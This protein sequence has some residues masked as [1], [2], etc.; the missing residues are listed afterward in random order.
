MPVPTETFRSIRTLNI[1]FAASAAF[2]L[3]ITGWLIVDDWTRAWRG[4]QQDARAWQ[5]VLTADTLAQTDSAQLRMDL[6]Q[7]EEEIR[8]MRAALP[9]QQLAD[10]ERD[11]A[12]MDK[13]RI[14]LELPLARTKSEIVPTEQQIE[15]ARLQY[16]EDA[17]ETKALRERLRSIII[18]YNEKS[19][20]LEKHMA[21]MTALTEKVTAFRKAEEDQKKD[22]ENLDR[23]RRALADK[24]SK[25]APDN[26]AS[27]FGE[28]LR[29]APLLDWFNPSEKIEQVIVPGVRTDLNFLTVETA[30]ACQTCHIN[31]DRPEFVQADLVKFLQR[32]V[33]RTQYQDVETIDDAVVSVEFWER[34]VDKLAAAGNA[35]VRLD[36]LRAQQQTL[37]RINTLRSEAADA[38]LPVLKFVED[39]K[40]KDPA[41]WSGDE[42]KMWRDT[43]TSELSRIAQTSGHKESVTR[44]R[45][46]EQRVI[47]VD[48]LQTLI[49]RHAGEREFALLQSLFRHAMVDQ[50]NAVRKEAGQKAVSNSPVMLAHPKLD[51]YLDAESPHPL[52]TMGCTVCHEGSGQDTSF[53]H[54][55]HTPRNIW[56]DADTGATV[57]EFLLTGDRGSDND[58]RSRIRTAPVEPSV[59]K[60]DS[61]VTATGTLLPPNTL[62][63]KVDGP[64]ATD[65]KPQAAHDHAHHAV[66]SQQD[67]NLLNPKNPAP[68]APLEDDH[69][70]PARGYV[71][72]ATGSQRVAVKQATY[73]EKKYH[74]HAVHLVDWEKP[75]HAMEYVQSSC[76]K[77]HTGHYDL[78][79]EAPKVFEGRKLFAQIG[80]ANCHQVDAIAEH[81]DIKKVGP[82]LAHV[83]EK[84]SPQMMATWIWSPKAFRPTSRMPHFFMLEN[85]SSPADILRT[86]TEVAAMTQYLLT[87]PP[88]SLERIAIL[89]Q[90]DAKL[91]A[92]HGKEGAATSRKLEIDKRRTAIAAEVEAL[93]KAGI[94]RYQPELPG[95]QAKVKALTDE[96]AKIEAKLKD[97]ATKPEDK[98]ALEQRLAAID[99]EMKSANEK[100]LVGDPARGRELFMGV[101]GAA[102]A[103]G[104]IGCVACHTN[105]NETGPDLITRDLV[106]R[107]NGMT[108]DKAKAVHTALSYNQ[109]HTYILQ[110]LP[111]HLNV[112]G[113]ELSG[114]GTKLK[115]G[116]TEAQALTW[117]YDWL[118]NP[119]HY[120]SYTIM[121]S[122]RLTE[123]EALDLAAYLLKQERPGADG[124]GTTWTPVDFIAEVKQPLNGQMLNELMVKLGGAADVKTAAGVDAEAKL[125]FVGKKLINHYNCQACHQINGYED[126]AS[127]APQLNDWGLKDP[128]KLDFGYFEHAESKRRALPTTVWKV[129]HEGLGADAAKITH[130][131]A[132][133]KNGHGKIEE[134]ELAWEEIH[135]DRRPWAI[136]KLHNTR[137]FDRGKYV[138]PA[139]IVALEPAALQ[140]EGALKK[141]VDRA[142]DKLKMPKF[143]MTDDQAQAIV[144]FITSIRKP[145][146]E[147]AL[148]KVADEA[149]QRATIGRQIAEKYNCY[150]CHNIESNSVA[151]QAYF[152]VSDEHGQF[153][154]NFER[155]M[156]APPRLI[157]QGAK[158]QPDWIAHFLVNVH[159]LR[160]WLKVRMPSFHYENGDTTGIAD[161]FAG[162]TTKD[163]KQI[164]R[165]LAPID[166]Q[167]AK[168]E[169]RKRDLDIEAAKIAERLAAN[170]KEAD[171]SKKISANSVT[172]LNGRLKQIE[173]QKASIDRW[174]EQ[175]AIGRSVDR[176]K[177]F[178]LRN[179]LAQP[180]VFDP[181][182]TTAD[183][184]A[185]TLD[186]VLY[187]TRF[188]HDTYEVQY[189]Y[190]PLRLPDIS[191]E[192]F[193]RGE[194]LF[195]T[196]LCGKCHLLGDEDKLLAVWKLENPGA[197]PGAAPKPPAAPVDD[198]DEAPAKPKPPA[199]PAA[200]KP[201]AA[202]GDDDYDDTPKTPGTPDAAAPPQGPANTAPNLR[203]VVHRI[204]PTWMEKWLQR[205]MLILPGTKMPNQW[206]GPSPLDSFFFQ[207]PDE[208]KIEA[209]K[210]FYYSGPEQRQLIMDFI[211]AAGMRN[212]TPGVWKLEGKPE[213]KV[214][215][216]EVLPPMPDEF[217]L[218]KIVD[219]SKPPTGPTVTGPVTAA[220]EKLKSDI[221]LHEG[222]AA[223]E[224]DAVLGHKTRLVGVIKFE[225]AKVGRRPIDMSSDPN[226]A[227]QHDEQPLTDNMIVNADGTLR[228]AFVQ[229]KSVPGKFDAPKSPAVIDQKGCIYYPHVVGVMAGQPLI[230]MNS[231]ATLHNVHGMPKKN[232]EFNVGQPAKGMKSEFMLRNPEENIFVK[233]DV[234]AWMNA[235]VHVVSHPFFHVSDVEGRYE[236]RGLPPGKYTLEVLHENPR[237]ERKAVEVEVKAD[238]STR[239]DVAVK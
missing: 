2:L 71:D 168:N 167:L 162:A 43:L 228:F 210:K 222:D 120:S 197:L 35:S 123:Q 100:P 119:T 50:F 124:D 137:L 155:L 8:R 24:L 175:P 117:L 53:F 32:Q 51:M 141:A 112:R 171:A 182:Q 89:M 11:L 56:V 17:P 176:L 110:Y 140:Q 22:L 211:Y 196:V 77:C 68:F 214:Q 153:N 21:G 223:Y 126:V 62:A 129:E 139:E 236:I 191:E 4:Y 38:T 164:A 107:E 239:V 195:N 108:P 23:E 188:L 70:N 133:A 82:S 58:I 227:R 104:G 187:A 90:E 208:A 99:G 76:T 207:F 16:G 194:A 131:S 72:P 233:C 230:V 237:V 69:H 193:A 186:G 86:R 198:Y 159:P 52:K 60:M 102:V 128:H 125:N 163:Q 9:K 138:V 229:I 36:Y 67:V 46:Y 118:R 189:P 156:N 42:S 41:T 49:K 83:K 143:F 157:G 45:W 66:I 31:I 203:H 232:P 184:R 88:A 180:R 231:D 205:S 177:Q 64:E 105:L 74:W 238:V 13:L 148:Q 142:Y 161:Y 95:A 160:P 34:A 226:C 103:D 113:P 179:D 147:P 27:K 12:A 200:P 154:G 221:V 7:K 30:D 78:R 174:S 192:R 54:V 6:A 204:Q 136:H 28:N 47:Y 235:R 234:H 20:E 172:A 213:P 190:P 201:A 217:E 111:K 73:W 75:M 10:A 170:E 202:A 144:T 165:I 63:A 48:D 178:A 81:K 218:P 80:C 29:N 212:Y 152:D 134:R 219:T 135:G 220:V 225:G 158:T 173:T 206:A 33:A 18:D 215:L 19:A 57:P 15:R 109:R 59:P 127:S 97:A 1:V 5:A 216:T 87:A 39:A 122:F 199:V 96:K 183:E 224:G 121:P 3:L 150:G 181:R 37:V 79:N 26:I 65:A 44:R 151:I 98:P 115:A 132:A 14:Q 55:A 209:H 116:R 146:V 91:V 85:N 145:L 94:A 169:V 25:L 185:T 106:K 61:L 93:K 84:L 101:P 92:E 114:V 149:G 166:T 40:E 130:E